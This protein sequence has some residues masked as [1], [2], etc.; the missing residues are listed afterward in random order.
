MK[1]VFDRFQIVE[2]GIFSAFLISVPLHCPKSLFSPGFGHSSSSALPQIS[3]LARLRSLQHTCI[4]LKLYS[5]R[6]SVTPAHLHCPKPHSSQVFGHSNYYALKNN[7]CRNFL[8]SLK[9]V[10]D[11]FFVLVSFFLVF[12]FKI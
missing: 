10:I 5:Y 1:P 9:P 6:D 4:A 3:F 8:D 12:F 2:K 11:R 7:G